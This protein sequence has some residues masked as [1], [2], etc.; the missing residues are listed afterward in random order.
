MKSDLFWA[1]K[2]EREIPIGVRRGEPGYLYT[3]RLVN[4]PLQSSPLKDH[5]S[6]ISNHL[7]HTKLYALA[8]LPAAG[9]S[10]SIDIP[11]SLIPTAPLANVHIQPER[12][13]AAACIFELRQIWCIGCTAH[14]TMLGEEEIH[15]SR[16]CL[17]GSSPTS[18]L[19]TPNHPLSPSW[20]C[21]AIESYRNS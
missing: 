4:R 16:P 14:S 18:R 20:P 21:A 9:I 6:P 2:S 8:Q 1:G 5:Q 15:V 10:Y 17:G 13:A 3:Q 7:S 11:R 19:S 12:S